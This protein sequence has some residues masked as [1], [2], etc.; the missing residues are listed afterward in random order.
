VYLLYAA[1]F[2]LIS[3]SAHAGDEV[4]SQ[5]EAQKLSAQASELGSDQSLRNST[6]TAMQALIKFSDNDIPGAFSTA[7]KA[8]GKFKTSENLDRARRQSLLAKASMGSAESSNLTESEIAFLGTSTTFRRLDPAFL[9][10]GDDAK[11]AA[12]F[13]KKT[14]ISGGE[15]VKMLASAAESKLYVSDPKLA[16][17]VDTAFENFIEK[18]PNTDFRM[19]VKTTLALV[20]SLQ[21][22]QLLV[23]GVQKMVAL[24]GPVTAP[25]VSEAELAKLAA[26]VASQPVA[27]ERV[28][29]KADTPVA[30]AA[31]ASTDTGV[32]DVTMKLHSD[33]MA[34][35]DDG[36]STQKLDSVFRAAV[37]S[38]KETIFQKISRKYRLITPRVSRD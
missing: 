34:R 9:S 32:E 38:E 31:S 14:G 17:K 7:Y 30:T 20:P 27:A 24:M 25:T 36:L 33:E 35:A 15:F 12:E 4:I 18:I 2:V 13:E 23:Q 11:I 28:P 19:K 3:F 37:E 10:K 1:I 5:A 8:Y 29:A 21:R 6:T 16:E 26:K 22:H